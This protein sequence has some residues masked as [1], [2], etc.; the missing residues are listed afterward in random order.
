MHDWLPPGTV[1]VVSAMVAAAS[2]WM[3]QNAPDTSE[4]AADT[5]PGVRPI[6]SLQFAQCYAI[7]RDARGRDHDRRRGL[8]GHLRRGHDGRSST[9]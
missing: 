3:I 9:R 4:N 2:V 6:A 8:R 5:I 1:L 7:P